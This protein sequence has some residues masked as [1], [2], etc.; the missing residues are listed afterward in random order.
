MKTGDGNVGTCTTPG[1]TGEGAECSKN[2]DCISLFCASPPSE[3]GNVCLVPCNIGAPTCDC[4]GLQDFAVLGY[5]WYDATN[6]PDDPGK[7]GGGG[8]EIGCAAS[9]GA[10][11]SSPLSVVLASLLLIGLLALLRRRHTC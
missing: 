4:R 1:D 7:G 9:S 10:Q 3:A 6:I 11:G 2:S 8:G 5:C